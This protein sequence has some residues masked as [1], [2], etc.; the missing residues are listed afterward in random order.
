MAKNKKSAG[1][2]GDAPVNV[3]NGVMIRFP[4]WI[5]DGGDKKRKAFAFIPLEALKAGRRK[6]PNAESLIA[7]SAEVV[8]ERHLVTGVVVGVPVVRGDG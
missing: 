6:S 7:D 2:P 4:A 1:D 8:D 5:L 3:V